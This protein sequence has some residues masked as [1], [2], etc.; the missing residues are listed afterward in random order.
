MDPIEKIDSVID[1]AEHLRSVLIDFDVELEETHGIGKRYVL[2][3]KQA[4]IE[5]IIDM[6]EYVKFEWAMIAG[7][8][9]TND[10][11]RERILDFIKRDVD[12]TCLFSVYESQS[13]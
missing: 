1:S 12:M 2:K 3:A 11:T 10:D 7:G 4:T 9:F 13:D 5:A 6:I 8:E